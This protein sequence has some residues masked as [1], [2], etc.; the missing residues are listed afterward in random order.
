MWR[1]VER[2]RRSDP[3]RL[4]LIDASNHRFT[5]RRLELQQAY[6]NAIGWVQEKVQPRPSAAR[7]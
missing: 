4:V 1:P 2:E 6:L 5:D 7:R 3:K